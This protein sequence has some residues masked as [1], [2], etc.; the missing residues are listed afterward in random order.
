MGKM[1]SMGV[2][3]RQ[4]EKMV[5]LQKREEEEGRHIHRQREKGGERK[6]QGKRVMVVTDSFYC[7]S[8]NKA[9]GPR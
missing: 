7:P 2:G 9:S 8:V 5:G 4:D 3:G 1:G 6:E